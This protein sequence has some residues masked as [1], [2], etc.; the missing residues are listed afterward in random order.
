MLKR[1][2][3]SNSVAA[4]ASRQQR[5][6][7]PRVAS[8]RPDPIDAAWHILE[9]QLDW[10]GKVDNKAS[11][12]LALES[13]I[14]AGLVTLSQTGHTLVTSGSASVRTAYH[15][16]IAFLV[17]GA[18]AAV[19]VV[20]P[21]LWGT[22]VNPDWHSSYIYFGHLRKWKPKDLATQLSKRELL[23]VLTR[24]LVSMSK[25]TWWK[26]VRVQISL[27]FA[28]LGAIGIGVAL[29]LNR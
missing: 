11:F 4:P 7:H 20:F 23:D 29:L 9:A 5:R 19:T 28:F 21:R 3:R 13:A 1:L 16:G 12:A 26:H 27:G 25:V 15:L 2:S 6:R 10:S 17:L 18:V 8:A 14:L 22:K 24:Q